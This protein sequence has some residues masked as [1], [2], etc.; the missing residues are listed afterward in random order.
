MDETTEN[1]VPEPAGEEATEESVQA[2]EAGSACEPG[3][4][5][6]KC[7]GGKS[8][9]FCGGIMSGAIIGAA[10]AMLL[11]HLKGE[12]GMGMTPSG[13]PGEAKG[14]VSSIADAAVSGAQGAWRTLR[15]RLSD[16][17]VEGKEGM[18]EGQEEA[19]RKHAFMARRNRHRR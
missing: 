8:R 12:K 4:S 10:L 5:C 1:A 18:S 3:C 7:C 16:A 15:E 2:P 11:K 19:R 13:E 17:W 6:E 9:G 14:Q